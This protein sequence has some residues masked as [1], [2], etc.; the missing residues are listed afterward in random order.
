[1]AIVRV[2]EK[3]DGPRGSSI[4]NFYQRTYTRTFAVEVSDPKVGALAARSA[5]GVPQP[6]TSYT[7]GLSGGDPLFEFDTGAF[8]TLVEASLD[9][10]SAG[11]QWTVTVQYAPFDTSAFGPDPTSWAVR[12][13]F[14]GERVEKVIWFDKAGNPIRNSAGDPF[15]DPI[16]I[17]DSRVVM[18]ITRNELVSTFGVTKP[19]IYNDTVNDAIWNGFAAGTCK[20]GVITTSEPQYDSSNHVYFLTVTY[21]VTIGR[22]PW[23]KNVLDQ[24]FN[25][26]IGTTP[27]LTRIKDETTGQEVSDPRPLD[28]SGVK[29][30]PTATPVTLPFDVYDATDWSALGINL[31]LRLGH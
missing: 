18:N 26:L 17:D 16:T 25:Q 30:A 28:G 6:G 24:G 11:L 12:V 31:A 19:S 15:G 7:N 29:L 27:K 2:S 9:P 5:S 1:M 8:V 21:P 22:T 3:V 20:M 23:I 14:G 10:G 13:S 4:N